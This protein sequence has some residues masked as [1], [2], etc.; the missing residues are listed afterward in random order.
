MKYTLIVL[1]LCAQPAFALDSCLVGNWQAEGAAMAQAMGA[2]SGASVSHAG[3]QTTLTIGADGSMAMA[4]NNMVF[5]M[6]MS[7]MPQMEVA[8]NGHS[9]GQLSAD[10]GNYT[11]QAGD[12]SLVGSADVM[13]QRMEIPVTSAAGGGWGN[14]TGSYTCSGNSLVFN[15][16]QLGSIPPRFARM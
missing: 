7:G 15:A 11:A 14:S 3:G 4:A 9:R 6:V 8:V 12:Y 1:A 13:G 2:Q 10:G 5:A 16:S